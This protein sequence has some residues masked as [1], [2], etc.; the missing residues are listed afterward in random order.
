MHDLDIL[1][2]LR[3]GRDPAFRTLVDRYQGI[4]LNCAFRFV[5]DRQTAE[6]L[7]QEVFMEV[8]ASLP[9][10]RG[11]SQLS[12]WIY[13]IAISKSLNHLK[14]MKRKKRFAFMTSLFGEGTDRLEVVAGESDDP[15]AI[16]EN[17]E[18]AR[19]LATALEALPENQRIAFTLGKVEGMSYQEIALVMNVSIPSVESLIHRARVRLR[20]TLM[21]HYRSICSNER[22]RP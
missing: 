2:D 19:L 21:D 1:N 5:R 10:F 8:Y 7:T 13:R 9:S 20:S 4:V 16:L 18:R 15:G 6:D 22:E 3:N 17:K 11:E 12:T 14:A